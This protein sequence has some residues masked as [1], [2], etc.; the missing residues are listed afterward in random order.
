MSSNTALASVAEAL[1][2]P[3]PWLSPYLSIARRVIECAQ[4]LGIIGALNL[5]RSESLRDVRFEPHSALPKGEPYEAYIARTRCIPT[6]DNVHD[7]F[8][9]IVWLTFPETKRRLNGLHAVEIDRAGI[10]DRRGPLRDALTLFDE[11]A[12]ILSAPPALIES[13][14]RRD[15]QTLCVVQRDLWANADLVLFGHALLEKLLHPRKATT[16]HVWVVDSTEDAAVASSL[17]TDRLEAKAF[18]PLPVLGVPGWWRENTEPSFY[19]DA[20][21]FRTAR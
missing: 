6:R 9:G 13:L 16:A 7:L 3:A 18:Y 4:S 21:V 15:W 2:D 19:R 5:H 11:N 20:A 1:V 8:N 14:R 17:T 10:S 12:A